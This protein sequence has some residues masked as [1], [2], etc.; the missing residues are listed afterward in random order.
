MPYYELGSLSTQ[1]AS[2]TFS[3]SQKKEAIRQLLQGLCHLHGRQA[4][5]RDIKPQN[6]LVET[7]DPLSL[8]MADFGQVSLSNPRSFCGTDGY[9]AP[10]IFYNLQQRDYTN[11][12]DI[13]SLGMLLLWFLGLDPI[14][15]PAYVFSKDKHDKEVGSKIDAAIDRT[16][17]DDER[18]AFRAAR[19][20]TQWEPDSRGSAEEW[21]RLPW[22]ASPTSA[23]ESP[24]LLTLAPPTRRS[25]RISGQAK[26]SRGRIQKS[27]AKITL[28]TN[29]RRIPQPIVAKAPSSDVSM[30]D[31]SGP[32][33]DVTEFPNSGLHRAQARAME[34]S[35]HL[36][37]I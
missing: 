33:R 26:A 20:M 10:E 36:Y 28:N 27:K 32:R 6:V 12:V 15:L 5:H 18:N 13:Y 19:R 21:L 14:N 2:R 35:S 24:Q 31:I 7:L 16:R 30:K 37:D 1:R 34:L 29:P 9:R 3:M 17:A 23:N 4:Q 11:A 8:L 25:S 22:L